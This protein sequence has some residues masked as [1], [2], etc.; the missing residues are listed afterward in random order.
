MRFLVPLELELQAAVSCLTCV[1]G[2]ELGPLEG[3][4]E[5]SHKPWESYSVFSSVGVQGLGGTADMGLAYCNSSKKKRQTGLGSGKS[6]T[7]GLRVLICN[8]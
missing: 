6:I 8:L 5:P 3:Q 7:L 1:L 2:T 4:H